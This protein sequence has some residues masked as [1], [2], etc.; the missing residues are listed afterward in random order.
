MLLKVKSLNLLTGRPVA[1]LHEKTA[2]ILS[3]YQG[4]RVRV[5]HGHS[6]AAIVNI[7]TGIL[8]ENEIYLSKEV[9]RHINAKESYAVEVNAE[10]PPHTTKFILQKLN[11]KELDE[12]KLLEIIGDIVHNKLTEAEIAYFVSGVYIHGMSNQETAN[13]SKSMAKFGKIFKLTG[14]VYDKHSIGG[15]AGNRTTP[16][17]VSI[18]AAAGLKMP[19]TS[20]RA[21]TS[22]AGTVDVIETMAK[23]EFSIAELNN[24]IK[25]AGACLVWGGSLGLAPADD[26]IICVERLIRLDPEAQLIASIL[27]KKLAVRSRGVLIDISYGKTAKKKTKKEAEELKS[28]FERVAKLLKLKIKVILT[29][30]SQP[31]GNGIGPVLEARDLLLVLSRSPRRPL[32]LE[33]KSINL[34]GMILEMSGKAKSGKGKALAKKLLDSGKAFEKFKDIIVA[35][36]G[37]VDLE[38]L[39]P[40]KFHC[41]VQS[42]KAGIIKEI[43]NRAIAGIARAAGCPTDKNSGIYLKVHVN[44]KVKKGEPILEIYAETSEKLNFARRS[45]ERLKPIL[46]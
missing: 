1:I 21:I 34:S 36:K 12:S 33:S 27:S 41:I 44:S 15:I 24:I 40:S 2:K 8:K 19:K 20:S 11:G 6:M 39:L 17:I 46:I 10:P 31:I 13:L 23:V 42:K 7:A 3:V 9:M 28:K 26:K 38:N 18:C 32:D 43:S 22:A 25:K 5:K 30:G 37:E 4:D 16:I 14:N 35:Q 45:Y 29:D